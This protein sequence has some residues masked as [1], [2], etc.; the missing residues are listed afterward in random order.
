MT[1][2]SIICQGENYR[3]WTRNVRRNIHNY[4]QIIHIS[5]AVILIDL[6]LSVYNLFW[7]SL[8]LCFNIICMWTV[9]WKP[10]I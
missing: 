6:D 4:C 3:P 10:W 7:M 9:F 1:D 5:D 8:N 2:I